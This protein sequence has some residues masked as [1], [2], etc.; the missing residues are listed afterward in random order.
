ML[1]NRRQLLAKAVSSRC[2][3]TGKVAWQAVGNP[4]GSWNECSED[5]FLSLVIDSFTGEMQYWTNAL[6]SAGELVGYIRIG[7]CLGYS[8]HAVVKF[9][10]LR[11][12]VQRVKSG[13]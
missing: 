5:N 6:T 4:G 3:S 9:P 7:G 13:C 2:M 8:D 1:D 11:D 10:L 12:I